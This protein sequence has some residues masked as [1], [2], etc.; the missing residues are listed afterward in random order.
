MDKYTRYT[1][2]HVSDLKIGDIVCWLSIETGKPQRDKFRITALPD[3]R[4][5]F[6]FVDINNPSRVWTRYKMYPGTECRFIRFAPIDKNEA[7]LE[8][9]KYLDKR[10]AER[11]THVA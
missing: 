10:F 4:G 5:Y 1:H 8:K 6:G 9:I 7:I 3:A 11:R 2:V